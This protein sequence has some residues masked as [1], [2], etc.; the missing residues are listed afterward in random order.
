[1]QQAQ[2]VKAANP[3]LAEK[4]KAGTVPLAQAAREVDRQKKREELQAKADAAPASQ[5]SWAPRRGGG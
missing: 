3:E 1:L 2:R 4:V 5:V